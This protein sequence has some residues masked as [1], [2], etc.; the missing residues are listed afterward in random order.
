MLEVGIVSPDSLEIC[1]GIGAQRS[2]C[3]VFNSDSADAVYENQYILTT[4]NKAS[5][6]MSSYS[7]NPGIGFHI[8]VPGVTKLSV[9]VSQ[10]SV[11]SP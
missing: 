4:T 9:E 8:K 3:V 11:I 1:D 2:S 10:K 6:F 7:P 5:I